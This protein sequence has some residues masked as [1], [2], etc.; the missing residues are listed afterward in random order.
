MSLY[1]IIAHSFLSLNSI[2]LHDVPQFVLF[3]DLKDLCCYH[4]LL[5]LNK[6]AKN[7]CRIL[8]GYCFTMFCPF[9]A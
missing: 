1:G 8:R 7:I 2:L 3:I 6:A 4:M 5:I 9:Y